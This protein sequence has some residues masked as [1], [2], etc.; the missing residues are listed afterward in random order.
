MVL[1]EDNSVTGLGSGPGIVL[2]TVSPDRAMI[3]NNTITGS[4]AAGVLVG[5]KPMPNAGGYVISG[6]TISGFLK[7]VSIDL[8]KHPGTSVSTGQ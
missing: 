3:R 5:S 6:N 4:G 2:N 8:V 7:S 1:V